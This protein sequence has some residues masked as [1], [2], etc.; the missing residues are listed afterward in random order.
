MRQLKLGLIIAGVVIAIILSIAYSV[1]TTP[2]KANILKEEVTTARSNIKIKEKRRFDLVRNLA[3]CIKSYD[4]HES[5]T[6]QAIAEARGGDSDIQE[7]QVVIK[8]VAEAYP[9]LKS[10][11]NYKQFMT[12]LAMTENDIANYREAYN[13]Q[14]TAYN[15]YVDR[16]PTSTFLKWCGY[17]KEN[18]KKLDFDVSEDAPQNLFGD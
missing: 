3:D 10:N 2:N 18:F 14:V 15:R 12:E 9:E 5:E 17:Q 8:S 7:A 1:K 13:N 16:F 6:L 4:K 11:E